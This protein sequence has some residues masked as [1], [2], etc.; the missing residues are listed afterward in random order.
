MDSRKIVMKETAIVAVGE[1]IL[2]AAMVGVYVALHRFDMKVLWSA[3][4]G[5]LVV[6]GNHF[7]MAIAVNLAADRAEKGDVQQAQKTLR[8]SSVF[9]F[10]AMGA[11]L[12]LCLLWKANAL[13]L[14]LPLLFIRPILM[15]SEFFRKKEVP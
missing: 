11:A 10:L 2:T 15:L 3:L 9:R 12:L 6:V 13:A 8:T 1:A 14:L 4:A 7:F 5:F